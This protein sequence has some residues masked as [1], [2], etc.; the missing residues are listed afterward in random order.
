LALLPL[1]SGQCSFVWSV[2]AARAAHLSQLSSIDFANELTQDSAAVL[3]DLTLR[4]ERVSVPLLQM[5]ASQ[6]VAER[7]AL[8]GDAAHVVHPLAGQGVNLGLLDA[9]ALADTALAA[10]QSGDDLG[11]L[12]ALRQYA[13]WRKSENELMQQSI[14]AFNRFLATGTDTLA[15]AAQRGMSWVGRSSVLRREFAQR[16]LGLAGELPRAARRA[17]PVL[18]VGL[19]L[20][21]APSSG[22]AADTVLASGKGVSIT[23]AAWSYRVLRAP[24][25]KA[26]RDSSISSCTT[27]RLE[28]RNEST[29]ELA[30]AAQVFFLIGDKQYTEVENVGTLVAPGALETPYEVE[31]SEPIDPARTVVV[32]STVAERNEADSGD[33]PFARRAPAPCKFKLSSAPNLEDY[34]ATAAVRADQEGV[35]SVRLALPNKSGT[36]VVLGIATSS[37]N[38]RIDR[39]ALLAVS[40]M[41]FTT[42]CP[43]T[44]RVLPVRFKLTN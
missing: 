20:G 35:A 40:R 28:I 5:T 43:G 27:T 24:E 44:Q 12:R 16:A 14:D 41:S 19:G 11:S 6:Y 39:G 10:R 1:A 37:G 2:P 32:C 15:L 38:A 26:C 18:L 13:R 4:S 22:Q 21:V 30:C 42:N 3:G 8:V 9:A 34:Y 33:A 31:V 25:R 29:L 23:R 36:P 17:L 7:C